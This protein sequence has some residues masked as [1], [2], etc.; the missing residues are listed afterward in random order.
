M[1]TAFIV[2]FQSQSVLPGEVQ[3]RVRAWTASQQGHA[4]LG[5]HSVLTWPARAL[6][7][8][9]LPALAVMAVGFGMLAWVVWATTASFAAM[10]QEDPGIAVR[11]RPRAAPSRRFRSGLAAVVIVKELKLIA[12]DPLLIAKS[13]V[14]GVALVPLMLLLVRKSQL[15]GLLGA[16]L[17]LLASMLAGIFA[18]IAVSGEEAPDLLGSSPVD[19]DR[20][21]WLKVAAALLPVGVLCTP[22]LA[23]YAYLSWRLFAIVVVFL[24]LS[25]ASAG[26]IQVWTGVPGSG[27]DLRVRNRKNILA[28][29]VES[30]ATFGWA[31]ACYLA[32]A[33]W[34][35]AA[36]PAAFF[37]LLGPAAAWYVGRSR[38][39]V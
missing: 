25:L 38:R 39:S 21:R 34:Y 37:G 30:M 7:G 8:D 16:S 10:A 27:R 2:V 11:G 24:T 1:A 35:L 5:S 36:L 9:P 23:W 6:L 3:A 29:L 28:N 14:Q 18:W 20:L 13:L 17:V 15:A 32:M 33:G 26:V 12:R 19:D 31:G 22:F 4:W